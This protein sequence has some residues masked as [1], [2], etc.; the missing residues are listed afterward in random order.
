MSASSF[1]EVPARISRLFIYPIKSCAGIEL[2]EAELTEAG[3]DLDR[4]WMVVDDQG[5]FVSQRELPRMAL[6]QVQLK[7]NEVI[8]RA[9]GMLSLHLH[10]DRVEAPA[11]VRVWDDVVPAYDMG[12]TAAQ[13]FSDFLGHKL[14]L[15]RFDPEHRRL[16]SPQWTGGVEAPNAFSDGFPLLVVSEA[17]LED[18]NV[19]LAA[20]GQAPVGMERFRPNIVLAG[21]QAH[22][23]D[24]LGVM[25]VQAD[26]PVQ[27]MP[28]KPCPRC[29]IPDIDPAT[30][31]AGTVVGDTLQA[32]R[33]NDK[34]GGAVTFGMNAIVR[35]GD[36]VMLRVGQSVTAAWAF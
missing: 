30:A 22:D 16:S 4:A 29:P 6:V 10:V 8:V 5:E 34:L 27:L 26:A 12:E 14:R 19:R 20:G 3:L 9:P 2:R 25:H 7:W 28:V 18:L 17:S 36:G 31:Q 1:S 15:V 24:R 11:K 21:L 35:E 13:W 23:E 33:R 32:Y